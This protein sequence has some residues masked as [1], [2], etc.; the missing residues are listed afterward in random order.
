MYLRTLVRAELWRK[1]ERTGPFH[2]RF[3]DF[4]ARCG[5]LLALLIAIWFWPVGPRY[6]PFPP[7][8]DCGK[9]VLPTEKAICSD[10]PHCLSKNVTRWA[11]C[12]R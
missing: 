4:A 2:P 12:V 9:A 3:A 10:P 1:P 8:F 6:M 7:S 11:S 5:V